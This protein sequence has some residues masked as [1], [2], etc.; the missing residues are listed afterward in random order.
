MNR[1]S[2]LLLSRGKKKLNDGVKTPG[3]ILSEILHEVAAEEREAEDKRNKYLQVRRD[4]KPAEIHL[5]Q[6][7]RI[8]GLKPENK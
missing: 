4:V 8:S 6:N 7:F 2:G 3:Q 1:N 5:T